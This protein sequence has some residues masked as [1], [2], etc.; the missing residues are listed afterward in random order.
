VHTGL[1][2]KRDLGLSMT[3]SQNK[4]SIKFKLKSS[5]GMGFR[6]YEELTQQEFIVLDSFD[7]VLIRGVDIRVP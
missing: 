1:I 4:D 6:S 7:P 5:T 3:P 2:C